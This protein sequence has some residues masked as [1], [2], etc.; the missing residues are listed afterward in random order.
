MLLTESV[1]LISLEI[2]RGTII[3]GLCSTKLLS[4]FI[5]RGL[6]IFKIVSR[7]LRHVLG[8]GK[9]ALEKTNL[10]TLPSLR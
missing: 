8:E 2:S 7:G 3:S 4:S 5:Y 10:F 1:K 6:V 9:K